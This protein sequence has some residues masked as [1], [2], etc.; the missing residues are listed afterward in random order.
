VSDI[1]AP[2]PDPSVDQY[3]A[4]FGYLLPPPGHAFPLVRKV[5]FFA[6]P[7]SRWPLT[8]PFLLCPPPDNF[9]FRHSS[10]SAIIF[11]RLY[12][13]VLTIQFRPSNTSPELHP[14]NSTPPCWCPHEHERN[15]PSFFFLCRLFA[16]LFPVC[17]VVFWSFFCF[18]VY[19]RG[20][21]FFGFCFNL[22][23]PPVFFPP[24]SCQ[25]GYVKPKQKALAALNCETPFPPSAFRAIFPPFAPFKPY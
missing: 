25:S 20:L 8:R 4:P 19:L 17:S 5:V 24:S 13:L 2:I 3:C 21:F 11:F 23:A 10:F 15:P 6:L 12:F 18:G 22:S 1:S 16:F 14:L 9:F 7:P